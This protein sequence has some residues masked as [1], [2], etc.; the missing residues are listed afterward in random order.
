MDVRP[1][2]FARHPAAVAGVGGN[3]ANKKWIEAGEYDKITQTARKL[4]DAVKNA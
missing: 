4:L 3:L 2:G 1:G